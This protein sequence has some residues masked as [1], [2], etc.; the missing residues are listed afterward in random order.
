MKKNR[1]GVI[2]VIVIGITIALGIFSTEENEKIK[3]GYH[4][5]LANSDLYVE[6]IFTDSFEIPE[7]NY[8]FSF[9]PNGDSP[10]ILSISLEGQSISFS[11]DFQL[12][13]TPHETGISVYYTW[14]Y[15]GSKKIKIHQ[16]QEIRIQVNPHD[17]LLGSVSI[18]LIPMK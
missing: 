5:T 15:L 4:I 16:D 6:G 8:E 3:E 17:N 9:V 11:E 7:G 18:D 1:I 2:I 10:K 14:D 13:G 12:K